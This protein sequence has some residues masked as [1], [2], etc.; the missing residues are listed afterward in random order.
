[1]LSTFAALNLMTK[2]NAKVTAKMGP[3][4]ETYNL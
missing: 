4:K 1:M 3:S 2:S